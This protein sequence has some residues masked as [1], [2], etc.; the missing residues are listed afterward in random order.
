MKVLRVLS[1][2]V[3]KKTTIQS[4]VD[5]TYVAQDEPYQ[6]PETI[7]EAYDN[8]R[9]Q[10][11]IVIESPEGLFSTTDSKRASK[12]FRKLQE[13]YPEDPP[14]ITV[15]PQGMMVTI[16]TKKVPNKETQQ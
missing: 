12:Q 15:I 4:E 5:A 14:V 7:S 10:N 1:K 9:Y 11:K 3:T 13:K 16:P 6:K 8:P 2:L